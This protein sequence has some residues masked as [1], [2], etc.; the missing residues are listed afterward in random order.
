MK[1]KIVMGQ[2]VVVAA[3]R[4]KENFLQS[5]VTIEKMDLGAIRAVPAASFYEG[6]G[7]L[8][9]ID[10][11]TQSLT[12][13]SVNTRGF[14][15]NRQVRIVQ[16][17]DGMDNQAPGLSFAVGNIVGISELDLE[18]VEILPGAASALYGPNAI[19]GLILMNSKSPFQYQGL[20][21]TTKVGSMNL[22]K[23]DVYPSMLNEVSVRYAKAFS[24]RFAF[25]VNAY[26][27]RSQDWQATDLRNKNN[28]RWEGSNRQTNPNY[29]GVNVYGDENGVNLQAV[30]TNPA[31]VSEVLN[32]L[33]A[34][35]GLSVAQLQSLIPA[36]LLPV[37]VIRR[38]I[39]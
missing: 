22:G 31:F 9:G 39:W 14:N 21:A 28:E 5:P 17:I 3:S 29:N 6:L 10:I 7:N 1:E 18:S 32:P 4:M 2:E 24:N 20:S 34:T 12:F 37:R 36:S 15:A 8:K 33:S 27:L 19:Q 26:Y 16:L 13:R 30:V 23:A 11:N 38:E 25:K 35:S